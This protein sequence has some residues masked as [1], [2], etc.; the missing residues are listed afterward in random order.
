MKTSFG[1]KKASINVA[2]ATAAMQHCSRRIFR[3]RAAGE[4]SAIDG[5]RA[6]VRAAAAYQLVPGRILGIEL[7]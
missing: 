1:R 3:A 6:C 7:N 2:M 4:D 5:I